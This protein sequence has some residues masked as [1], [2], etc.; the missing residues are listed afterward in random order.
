L[1]TLFE[2]FSG[3]K[4]LF[5]GTFIYDKIEW[6]SFPIVHLSFEGVMAEK[7]DFSNNLI[8]RLILCATANDILID[9]SNIKTATYTLV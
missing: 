9:E 1:N 8:K 2:I 3:N 5:E 4:A 7:G 6:E